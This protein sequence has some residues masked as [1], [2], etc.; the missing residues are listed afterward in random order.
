M[1]TETWKKQ[2]RDI[3]ARGVAAWRAGRRSPTTLFD[4]TDLAFLGSIG[5]S[6][7]ELFDFI[8][9]LQDYGEPDFETVLEVQSLRREYF[10]T[11]MASQPSSH[12]A[13]M[14]ELPA[15]AAAVDGIAWLPRLIVKARLKLRGEMP[16]DLMYG[17]GGDRP[18]LRRMNMTLPSFLKLVWD[19]GDDDRKIVDAVKRA[20]AH[21]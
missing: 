21:A 6:A 16:A 17:C 12:I 19:C 20:A 14:H 15:K 9:D 18:F 2:L 8:D 13:S 11:V 7:Q 10:K 4:P 3:H 1:P 5:C